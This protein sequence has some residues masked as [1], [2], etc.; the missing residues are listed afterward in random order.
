M[1]TIN[2]DCS[3]PTLSLCMSRIGVIRAPPTFVGGAL[4][5]SACP[6]VCLSFRGHSN[7]VIFLWDF[8]QTS[9]MDYF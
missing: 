3:V 6:S 5:F 2:I 1:G 8:F 7:S 4:L 9:Y